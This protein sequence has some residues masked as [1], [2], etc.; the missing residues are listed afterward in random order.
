[1]TGYPRV[2]LFA[3]SFHEVNGAAHTCRQFEAFARRHRHEFL[4]VRCGPSEV[5]ATEGPVWTLEMRRGGLAFGIDRDLSFDPL[6]FRRRREVLEAVRRFRPDVIHITSPGDIGILGAWV[7][8]VARVPLIASWH[9]NLHEFAGRRLM[10]YLRR[11]P[12]AA[13]IVRFVERWSLD[14]VLWFFSRPNATLAPNRELVEM[15][16]KRSGKPS[17]LMTRGIDVEMFSPKR[18]VPAS[19]PLTIGFVGRLMPEKNVRLLVRLEREL[20]ASGAPPVQ[21]LVV[22]GGSE[23]P[24]L[25]ANLRHAALPGVLT[26]EDLARAYAQ[27]DIFVFPSQTDTFG[28]VVLEAQA[29]GVPAVVMAQGGPKFLVEHGVTGMVAETEDDVI[30]AVAELLKEPWRLERM[31]AAARES[32]RAYS[33]ENVFGSQVYQAYC[34]GLENAGGRLKARPE[35]SPA[36]TGDPVSA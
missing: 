3:D 28:N 7:A 15:I 8:H 4:C 29:S 35:T 24:W 17:F 18:R 22:G 20:H 27:M 30:A 1:M 23:E 16:E 12:G 14:R 26:G 10:K 31:R 2:A 33:W 11:L 21:F 25:R 5:F 13:A 32:V 19:G 9:T 36:R 34:A 6:L